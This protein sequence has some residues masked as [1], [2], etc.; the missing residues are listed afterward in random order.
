MPTQARPKP[1]AA[2][3]NLHSEQVTAL[4][5]PDPLPR[6]SDCGCPDIYFCPGSQEVE[7]P[8]HSGFDSCCD[9]IAGHIRVR[10]YISP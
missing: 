1:A 2:V 5:P 10:T 7:C 6:F 9:N 3:P 4:T 8:R